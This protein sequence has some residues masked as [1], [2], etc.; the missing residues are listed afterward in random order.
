ME[1]NNSLVRVVCIDNKE[2]RLLGSFDKVKLEQ[3]ARNIRGSGLSAEQIKVFDIITLD[4]GGRD[5]FVALRDFRIFKEPRK[6]FSPGSEAVYYARSEDKKDGLL[7]QY[8]KPNSQTSRHYHKKGKETYYL[9]E[10]LAS[11]VTCSHYN[12]PLEQ[13]VPI[14]VSQRIV[15]QVVTENDPSIVL[16]KMRGPNGFIG[17]ED[18]F[19]V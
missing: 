15:H 9:V 8:L 5:Y 12:K 18:H 16:L 11:L 1:E 6:A 14:T 17:A 19:Y 3:V 7:L 2:V 4:F 10:G 13:G